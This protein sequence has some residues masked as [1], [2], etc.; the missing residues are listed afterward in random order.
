MRLNAATALREAGR[1]TL[2]CLREIS[3]EWD[4]A[5]GFTEERPG[6]RKVRNGVCFPL[7]DGRHVVIPSWQMMCVQLPLWPTDESLLDHYWFAAEYAISD[8]WQDKKNAAHQKKAFESVRLSVERGTVTT[9]RLR[10]AAFHEI[11]RAFSRLLLQ[12]MRETRRQLGE[13]VGQNAPR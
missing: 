6:M 8:F 12:Q 4:I 11:K 3:E 10:D 9:G 2:Q 7:L 5:S 13:A 1:V